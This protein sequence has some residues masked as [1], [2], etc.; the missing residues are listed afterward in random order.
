MGEAKYLTVQN[1]LKSEIY[2]GN[3]PNGSKLPSENELMQRFGYSRQTIRQALHNLEEQEI[4]KRLKGSGTYV[5]HPQTPPEREVKSFGVILNN[6]NEPG[7]LEIMRG[8]E[9][10]LTKNGHSLT[11]A[12]TYN[13][14]DK[15]NAVLNSMMDSKLDGLIV[16]G[17]K[18]AV[19]NPSHAMYNKIRKHVPCVFLHSTPM[20][21]NIPAVSLNDFE[22]GYIA[23]KHLIEKGHKKIAAI[24]RADE[25]PAHRH[26]CGYV[27][28]LG[29]ANIPFSD[30]Y[31]FWY[32]YE[33]LDDAFEY[34]LNRIFF[35]YFS[36][37]T[38]IICY[39]SRVVRRLLKFLQHI[40]VK[41]FDDISILSLESTPYTEDINITSI[42]YDKFSLGTHA[43][44]LCLKMLNKQ[45]GSTI[46][47]PPKLICRD[48]VHSIGIHG[49]D[50]E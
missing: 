28:A 8:I 36:G 17:T 29:E 6:L 31:I 19:V 50:P 12:V 9:Q 22:A 11:L 21:L 38:A 20:A 23:A 1:W 24:L 49:T 25:L 35:K 7:Q 26:Y 15:E 5:D 41:P 33:D 32:G 37:C 47:L 34:V 27:R 2:K 18:T 16:E 44:K 30:N 4:V 10:T 13:R 14:H 40:H 42:D 48:S 39:N 46:L 45:A 43:V 3:Y